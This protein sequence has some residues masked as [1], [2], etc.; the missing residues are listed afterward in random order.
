MKE[1]KAFANFRRNGL[2]W[3][4][5]IT[6]CK[7]PSTKHY[8]KSV[9]KSRTKKRS[10]ENCPLCNKHAKLQRHHIIWKKDGGKGEGNYLYICRECHES[11]HKNELE[12][13]VIK[14][15]YK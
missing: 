8:L 14:T 12:D 15:F 3:K 2:H 13:K 10:Y 9:Y 6:I 5:S 11:I 4:N 7:V 1:E